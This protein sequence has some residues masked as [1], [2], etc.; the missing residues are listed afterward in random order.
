MGV[1]AVSLPILRAE[2]MP[3]GLQA[4]GFEQQ[5]A[6]LFSVAAWLREVFQDSLPLGMK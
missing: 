3:L 6:A 1:P 4:L 5:D 2:D